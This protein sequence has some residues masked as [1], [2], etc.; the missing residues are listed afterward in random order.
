VAGDGTRCV[1]YNV[2][3]S[4]IGLTCTETCPGVLV[5]RSVLWIMAV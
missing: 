2:V 3:T 4:V 1:R 5:S